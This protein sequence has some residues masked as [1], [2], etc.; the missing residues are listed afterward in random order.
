ESLFA[1]P[2][3]AAAGSLRQLDPKIAA[4][5]NLDI[6]LYGYGLWEL[7]ENNYPT[8]SSRLNLLEKIGYKVNQ[9]RKKYDNIKDVISYVEYWET[10]SK[11]LNYKIDDIISKKEDINDQE[12]IRY[13]YRIQHYATAYK[14]PATQTVTTF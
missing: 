3:N 2:R 9:E 14:F 13:T 4:S 6:F 7:D 1:N 12:T 5:R 8:H 11:D 10:H